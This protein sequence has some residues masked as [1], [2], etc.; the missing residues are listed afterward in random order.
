MPWSDPWDILWGG[1]ASVPTLRDTL[2]YSVDDGAGIADLAVDQSQYLDNMATAA[3]WHYEAAPATRF[4][5]ASGWAHDFE[6]EA[7]NTDTGR[8]FQYDCATA[9]SDLSLAIGAGGVITAIINNAAV[10]T[11]LTLPGISGTNQRFLLSWTSIA[12]PDTT[13]AADA[14][15]HFL[16]GW[17]LDT[18]AFDKVRFT[19]V[20][21]PTQT[22]AMVVW[23]GTVAGGSPFT[24][25]PHACRFSTAFHTATETHEEMVGQ[26]AEPDLLGEERLVQDMPPRSSGVGDDGHFAG[27]VA[28]LGASIAR[29]SDLRL[30]GPL[31]SQVY[32]SRPILEGDLGT[33]NAAWVYEDPDVDAGLYVYLQYCYWALVP[34]ACNYAHVRV[35]IQSFST[36]QLDVQ[37]LSMSQPGR[38]V[39]PDTS[40]ITRTIYRAEASLTTNHGAG[41][42]AGE[43][44]DL[45]RLRVARDSQDGSYFALAFRAENAGVTWRVKALTIDPILYQPANGPGLGG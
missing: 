20:V 21:R 37:C 32:R 27:P 2:Y 43:W 26:S 24:G 25:I 35:F 31:V 40:P 28:L 36:D 34:P 29:D 12:N 16:C 10:A 7:D 11:T 45:G 8:L 4:N 33:A 19:T 30:V 13:G 22:G 14:L 5:L 23:A 44:V 15:L 9:A 42:T 6:F 3:T 1:P 18:G 38:F 41:G 39:R 17:N